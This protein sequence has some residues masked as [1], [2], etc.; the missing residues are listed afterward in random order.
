M[1]NPKK[2]KS[3]SK[4]NMRRSHDGLKP[5]TTSIC[6]ECREPKLPHR[7]CAHCGFYKDRE[8]VDTGRESI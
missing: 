2:R 6:P 1:A 3:K 4:R 7:V 8:V 5:P